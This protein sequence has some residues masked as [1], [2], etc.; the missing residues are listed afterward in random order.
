MADPNQVLSNI[1]TVMKQQAG[2]LNI[3]G[4]ALDNDL[5]ASLRKTSES[6]IKYTSSP[7]IYARTRPLGFDISLEP[8]KTAP[9]TTG[10]TSTTSNVSAQ[11]NGGSGLLGGLGGILQSPIVILGLIAILAFRK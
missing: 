3:A 4:S 5:G 2:F 9:A 6:F 8:F 7:I 11:N 10:S 1:M